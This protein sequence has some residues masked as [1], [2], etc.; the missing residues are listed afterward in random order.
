MPSD[1]V[2]ARPAL[3]VLGALRYCGGPQYVNE[4]RVHETESRS[5]TSTSGSI[6]TVVCVCVCALSFASHTGV[7]DGISSFI[8]ERSTTSK[9]LDACSCS[10]W[11]TLCAAPGPLPRQTRLPL[12]ETGHWLFHRSI[13]LRIA[14]F[15]T[16]VPSAQADQTAESPARRG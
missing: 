16:T 14:P 9:T 4:A 13:C 1:F 2:L 11:L 10:T 5:R 7:K 8:A 15:T 3:L 12:E 6:S